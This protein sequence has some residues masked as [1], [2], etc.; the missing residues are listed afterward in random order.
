MDDQ[1]TKDLARID[2]QRD[3]A[4][5][6]NSA[7]GYCNACFPNAPS[8]EHCDG[9]DDLYLLERPNDEALDCILTILTGIDN[10][11]RPFGPPIPT[12]RPGYRELAKMMLAFVAAVVVAYVLL[13]R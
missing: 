8:N 9:C 2:A 4:E 13:G 12:G 7:L 1:Q 3:M 6:D 5:F 11:P 10:Y